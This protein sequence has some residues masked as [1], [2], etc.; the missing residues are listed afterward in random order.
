MSGSSPFAVRLSRLRALLRKDDLPAL[1]VTSLA[2][3]RYLTGF[4]GSDGALLVDR[5]GATFVTDFRYRLQAEREV[6]CC[7]RVERKGPLPEALAGIVRKKALR[8][9]GFECRHLSF[10]L[11]RD[12]AKKLPGVRLTATEGK[13]EGLRLVKDA[14]E[15]RLLRRAVRMAGLSYRRS[16]RILAG[17]RE[18]DVAVSLEEA[19]RRSGAESTAFPPIVASGPRGALP[20][21]TPGRRRIRKGDLVV[22]DFGARYR[23]YHSDISRTRLPGNRGARAARLCRVVAEAQR[24]A[25]RAVRPGVEAKIVDRAARRVIER[26]GYAD[27]FG[28]GTGHGVGLEVHEGPTISPRS[29]DVLA[30]GMVFTVEPGIYIEKFGGVRIED[31]VLVTESGCEIL[32]QSIPQ[33]VY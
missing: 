19:V 14:S 24:E 17:R 2:N 20:H 27:C 11:H 10:S 28:H 16:A 22:L 33:Q 3:V 29:R 12:L 15:V 13:V 23:G 7:R 31:M 30:P 8:R 1:L 32:S 25:L 26:A 6:E 18:A 21:A 5:R 4:T 9:A